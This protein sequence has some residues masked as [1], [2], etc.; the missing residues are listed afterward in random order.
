MA[1]RVR[2]RVRALTA[3]PL[4]HR[5]VYHFG[6]ITG[7]TDA[8]FFVR[9]IAG[10]L[11]I[12]AFASFAVAAVEGPRDSVGGFF[13]KVGSSFYWAI[14]MVLGA[15]DSSYVQTPGGYVISWLL[16][17]FGVA[18][19]GIITA[20][21]VGFV[22]DFILKEG[23]GMGAAGFRDHIVVCGW[24]PTAREL[25]AELAGDEYTT[26]IVVVHEA[27]KNPA[28][29]GVYFV[30]GDPTDD[31]DL[32]RAGIEDAQA[33][34]VCPSDSTNDADM[35]S[36]LTVMAIK[37]MAPKVRTVVEANNPGHV[38][39]FQRARADEIVVPSSI[40]SRLMAR[41]SLY[42][43]LAD[44]V[45]NIVSGGEGSELYRVDLPAEYIGLTLDE[46][47]AKMRSEHQATVLGINR[48]GT[49]YVNPGTDFHLQPG[50]DAVVVAES[51][52]TLSPL[53]VDD[54]F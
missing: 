2:A 19:V 50:D 13:G 3:V 25:I 51:L 30:N 53:Q 40:T 33:A 22:I 9:P 11:V 7:A 29:K 47:A 5:V 1:G 27:D 45:T 10:L 18:I 16:V 14:T 26:K 52:G 4:L 32:R 36:I 21:L 43:G 39:H 23:Q 41:S 17:L 24:N 31:D 42:P 20:A 28:G 44:I 35:R 38:E 37:S 49:A 12:V 6:R 46:L 8:R 34:I 54:D 15:G 48:G